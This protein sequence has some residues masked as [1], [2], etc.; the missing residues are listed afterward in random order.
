MPP[1]IDSTAAMSADKRRTT[2]AVST[3]KLDTPDST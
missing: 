2:A 1:R 3:G